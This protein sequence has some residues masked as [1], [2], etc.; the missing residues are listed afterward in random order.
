MKYAA[1][2][3]EVSDGACSWLLSLKD[4]ASLAET[5][6]YG[7]N[8]SNE[9]VSEWPAKRRRE[10]ERGRRRKKEEVLR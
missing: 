7:M 5:S 3:E 6:R 1:R 8:L 10:L 9:N 2:E 4:T